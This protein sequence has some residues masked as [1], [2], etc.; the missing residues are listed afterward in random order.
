M[1]VAVIGHTGCT[2]I[3]P[4]HTG[5]N[6]SVEVKDNPNVTVTGDLLKVSKY[7]LTPQLP[8]TRQ[9]RR[10]LERN[11]NKGHEINIRTNTPIHSERIH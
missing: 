8:L 9:Q 5:H 11:R 2:S 3:G 6:I 10:K 1:K 7:D 4:W